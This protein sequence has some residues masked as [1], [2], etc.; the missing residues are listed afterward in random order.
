MMLG[1]TIENIFIVTVYRKKSLKTIFELLIIMLVIILIIL[2][3][4]D[5]SF[6]S[7]G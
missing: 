3:I 2:N 1:M 5:H 6:V 7:E 4:I